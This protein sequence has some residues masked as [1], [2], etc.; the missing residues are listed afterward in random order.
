MAKVPSP[1]VIMDL[2]GEKADTSCELGYAV[3]VLV[4]GIAEGYA[5][6]RG[7]IVDERTVMGTE[8]CNIGVGS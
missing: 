4:A 8:L 3:D 2:C 1:V 6:R 7:C 5:V